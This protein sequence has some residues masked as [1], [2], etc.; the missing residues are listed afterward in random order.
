MRAWHRHGEAVQVRVQ[1]LISSGVTI[2]RDYDRLVRFTILCFHVSI[3]IRFLHTF[4]RVPSVSYYIVK[5]ETSKDDCSPC[6]ILCYLG[7]C[8]PLTTPWEFPTKVNH[9][10]NAL[11][12]V[13]KLGYEQPSGCEFSS[14][15]Y[16]SQVGGLGLHVVYITHYVITITKHFRNNRNR[17][18]IIE[19]EL[20]RKEYLKSN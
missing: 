18:A 5:S 3:L 17:K 15:F 6:P 8:C 9:V 19:I 2:N 12:Q 13:L 4:S 14:A 11:C 16:Y 7:K 20:N 10:R 1:R